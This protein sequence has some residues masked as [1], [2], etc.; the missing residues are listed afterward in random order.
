MSIKDLAKIIKNIIWHAHWDFR[1]NAAVTT[2]QAI[3]YFLPQVEYFLF[4]AKILLVGGKK[5]NSH[6]L[7]QILAVSSINLV[8]KSYLLLWYNMMK[9]DHFIY[10][11]NYLPL[12]CLDI[13][14]VVPPPSSRCLLTEAADYAC[15]SACFC[16]INI[17]G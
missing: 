7:E 6:C 12:G 13:A 5:S 9:I 4:F 1:D 11:R 15:C 3:G 14:V 17:V 8:T 2:I 10:I 16:Q